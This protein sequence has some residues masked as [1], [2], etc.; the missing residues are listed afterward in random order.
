MEE[1]GGWG[2][3]MGRNPHWQIEAVIHEEG[4]LASELLG[5]LS[6]EIL[7]DVYF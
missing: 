1:A 5:G 2:A 4:I 7:A 3:R 6:V